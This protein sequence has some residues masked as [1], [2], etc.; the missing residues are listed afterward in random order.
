MIVGL[1][2]AAITLDRW[3]R[4]GVF[5][6]EVENYGVQPLVLSMP[7]ETAIETRPRGNN[8]LDR[9]TNN[10]VNCNYMGRQPGASATAASPRWS[11]PPRYT[12]ARRR[13]P[14]QLHSHLPRTARQAPAGGSG[15][16]P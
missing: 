3:H 13:P 5:V 14:Y 8:L 6:Q 15:T 11:Q 4:R 16:C 2:G 12:A 7:Q 10:S 9:G 1:M